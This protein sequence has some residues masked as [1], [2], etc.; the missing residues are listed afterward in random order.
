MK[1]VVWI[2]IG[3]LLQLLVFDV[4]IILAIEL[5]LLGKAII[6]ERVST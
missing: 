1:A 2:I 6:V 4:F 5:K 3:V